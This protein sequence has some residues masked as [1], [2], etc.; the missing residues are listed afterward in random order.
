MQALSGWI[1][2]ERAGV[3]GPTR[4]TEKRLKR[5]LRAME[6]GTPRHKALAQAGLP[7]TTLHYWVRISP[8][9]ENLAW[10][11]SR[12]KAALAQLQAEP[13]ALCGEMIVGEKARQQELPFHPKCAQ[14]W[15]EMLWDI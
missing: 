10:I 2:T 1:N 3:L 12:Y 6:Q 13:C 4:R 7:E 15:D 11:A 9:H 5:M 14:Q 8:Q